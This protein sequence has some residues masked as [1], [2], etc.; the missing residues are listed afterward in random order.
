MKKAPYTLL[1]AEKICKD[2]QYLIGK[3]FSPTSDLIIESVTVTPYDEVNKKRFLIFYFL[4][5]NAE[6]ALSH[7]Y[8]G[9][10]FDII[11]IGRSAN[12]EH[13]LL[14]ED[15]SVWLTENMAAVNND[16]KIPGEG[17]S[18]AIAGNG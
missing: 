12:D 13:D 4:F 15:L 8:R 14:Q 11:V 16:M 2:H 3:K 6:S 9:F 7:E 5:N 18:P 10:L 17:E 1:E